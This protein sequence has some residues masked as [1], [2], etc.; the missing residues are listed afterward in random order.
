[1]QGCWCGDFMRTG[2]AGC[3]IAGISWSEGIF[4]KRCAE[5]GSEPR[6]GS[7][8]TSLGDIAHVGWGHRWKEGVV[9][10]SL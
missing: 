1:M 6:P 9:P 4:Y 7:Y 10:R 5:L 2:L 8:V 3:E